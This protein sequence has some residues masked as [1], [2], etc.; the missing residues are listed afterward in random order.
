MDRGTITAE[1]LRDMR[2]KL[3]SCLC[4]D[5]LNFSGEEAVFVVALLAVELWIT[6]DGSREDFENMHRHVWDH[7][8]KT[9]VQ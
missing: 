4:D 6:Q 9:L 7:V 8:Q 3:V 1:R 2:D 5:D